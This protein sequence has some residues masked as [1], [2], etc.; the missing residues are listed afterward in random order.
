MD[1][2]AKILTD[3]TALTYDMELN[4]PELYKFLDEDPITLPCN[5][6]PNMNQQILDDYRSSLQQLL[7]H[8]KETHSF[9]NLVH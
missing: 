6:H 1:N 5:G 4:Y 2:V 3:I 7:L 8:H 9:T